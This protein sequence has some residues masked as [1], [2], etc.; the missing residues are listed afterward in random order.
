M[1]GAMSGDAAEVAPWS[2]ER[3][4]VECLV[5]YDLGLGLETNHTG[6]SN[7]ESNVHE[8]CER[9]FVRCLILYYRECSTEIHGSRVMTNIP[10]P[11]VFHQSSSEDIVS[12]IH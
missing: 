5:L 2:N 9:G 10:R 7:G 6:V 4:T 11:L 8:L 12:C 1:R 3:G